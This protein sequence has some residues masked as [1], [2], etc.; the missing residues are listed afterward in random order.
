MFLEEILNHLV[1]SIT[2]NS[3]FNRILGTCTQYGLENISFGQCQ[4]ASIFLTINTHLL[5]EN[6][7]F[8]ALSEW[9]ILK[10]ILCAGTQNPMN[11][12]FLVMLHNKVIL[13]FLQKHDFTLRRGCSI[14]MGFVGVVYQNCVKMVVRA[15]L[16]TSMFYVVT[17][18]SCV[19]KGLFIPSKPI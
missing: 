5:W 18:K 17:R 14:K 7:C 6:R 3:K 15:S 10:T 11:L 12:L 9:D 19:F 4:E 13:I 8:L 1:V 2:K 16:Y